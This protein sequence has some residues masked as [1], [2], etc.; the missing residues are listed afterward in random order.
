MVSLACCLL[1][2]KEFQFKSFKIFVIE[3]LLKSPFLGY[4]LLTNFAPLCCTI[5]RLLL[6]FLE[7]GDQHVDA[8]SRIGWTH[9]LYALHFTDFGA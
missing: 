8:D 5:S 6:S 2:S 9:A 4:V 3:N 7:V 1:F